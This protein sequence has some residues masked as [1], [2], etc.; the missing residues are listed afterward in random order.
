MRRVQ[1]A[2]GFATVLRHGDDSAGGAL[3]VLPRADGGQAV[4]SRVP[5]GAGYAWTVAI[6]RPKDS[7]GDISDFLARQAR[8]DPDVWVIE[9]DIPSAERFIDEPVLTN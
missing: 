4:L 5:H 7:L 3:L 1:G 6:D 9:L 2:G 8:Y